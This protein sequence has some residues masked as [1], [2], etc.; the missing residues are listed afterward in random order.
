MDLRQSGVHVKLS[1]PGNEGFDRLIGLALDELS[2]EVVRGRLAVR[3]ELK[4][5]GGLLHGGVYAAVAE[6]LA[7]RGTQSA[8]AGEGKRAIGI[9]NR[10]NVL[11]PIAAG[12]LEAVAIRRHRGRTTWVWEV[13]ISDEGGELCVLGRVT[14]AVRDA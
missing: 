8:L 14:V 11:R 3:E 12:T 6:G 13:Q 4:E 10:T 2:E 9:A 7:C 1:V 5:P